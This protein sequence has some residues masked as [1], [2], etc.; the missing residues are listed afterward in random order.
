M[1]HNEK[2]N[3]PLSFLFVLTA[4]ASSFS[5]ACTGVKISSA[6]QIHHTRLQMQSTKKRSFGICFGG[7][8]GGGQTCSVFQK[9]Q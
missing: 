5:Q 4:A 1:N 2:G 9:C 8:V 7:E 6:L 3:S